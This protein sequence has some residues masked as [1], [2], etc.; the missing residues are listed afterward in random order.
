MCVL[1]EKSSVPGIENR[2][3]FIKPCPGTTDYV[4]C[5]YMIIDFARG[6]TLGCT[7][8]ILSYYFNDK[9]PVFFINR[10]KLFRELEIFLEE[11]PDLH[12]FGTGEFTDS[13][14]FEKIAPLYF[15]LI[16]YISSRSNAILEIK[17]KTTFIENL[18]RIRERRN[19]IVGWSLNTDYIALHEERGAA[20]IKERI[21]AARIIEEEGYKLSFHFDPIIWY[22]GW[23]DGYKRTID[24]LFNSVDPKSVVYI[25]MGALR[26]F[27]NM[28]RELD[29]M[30]AIYTGG[31]F[32]R[33]IDG[34]MRYFRPIRTMMYRS[35]LSFLKNYISED[36]IYLCMESPDVW[37]DVF[38][39]KD[40]SS[41]KLKR[42][43]DNLCM[44]SFPHLSGTTG[45]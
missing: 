18:L 2:G 41:G 26:F 36:N 3:R 29:R 22:E 13:L 1:K 45:E 16:P 33:G 14:L 7:Y 20:K 28:K 10:E 9:T 17:T 4:C 35:V 39:I 24:I 12:R 37:Q 38:N 40:M 30:G 25:S 19:I 15:T 31:E 5:G 21:N 44:K 6:C 27:P 32:I 34:K 11:R 23:E 42:R 43:L 8:C